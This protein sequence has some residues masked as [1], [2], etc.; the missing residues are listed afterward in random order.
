MNYYLLEECA[1]SIMYVVNKVA[2]SDIHQS[3]N[4]CT[5]FVLLRE[6]NLFLFLDNELSD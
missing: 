5:S 2:E 3:V 4:Q 6:N 1:L